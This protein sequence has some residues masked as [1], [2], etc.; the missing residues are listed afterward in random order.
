MA[1]YMNI[2]TGYVDTDENWICAMTKAIEGAKEF[3][4]YE[5]KIY[6]DYSVSVMK[7]LAACSEDDLKKAF[8]LYVEHGVLVAV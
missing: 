6:A 8:D 7:K 3:C 1:N 5:N 2:F 4:E